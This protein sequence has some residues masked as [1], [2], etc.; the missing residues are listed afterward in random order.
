[1]FVTW[2]KHEQGMESLRGCIGTLTPMAISSLR[3][4]TYSRWSAGNIIMCVCVYVLCVCVIWY[5]CVYYILCIVLST[6]FNIYVYIYVCLSVCLSVCFIS[7]SYLLVGAISRD[8]ERQNW[9]VF[10]ILGPIFTRA[11]TFFQGSIAN[12]TT[13][14]HFFQKT[15]SFGSERQMP[16]PRWTSIRSFTNNVERRVSVVALKPIQAFSRTFIG[17]ITALK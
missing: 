5:E 17:N 3:D 6:A 4:Y 2:D 7:T 16:K 15:Q 1:M 9:I 13:L 12:K 11:T 10:S 14:R 8:P